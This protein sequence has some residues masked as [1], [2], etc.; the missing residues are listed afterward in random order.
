MHNGLNLKAEKGRMTTE[1]ANRVNGVGRQGWCMD[2][3]TRGINWERQTNGKIRRETHPWKG[4]GT[5]IR[6]GEEVGWKTWQRVSEIYFLVSPNSLHANKQLFADNER[7]LNKLWV[8]GRLLL[9]HTR[10]DVDTYSV[11]HWQQRRLRLTHLCYR[12]RADS[13]SHG[14]VFEL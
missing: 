13:A 14:G 3:I 12:Q 6:A 9:R 10:A 5:C 11:L 8:R 1:N 4:E 2:R 7:E